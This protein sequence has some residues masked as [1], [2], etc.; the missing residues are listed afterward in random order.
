MKPAARPDD[1][2]TI[3]D[4]FDRGV[5]ISAQQ[6]CLV[7]DTYQAT[8][9]QVRQQSE[10][11]AAQLLARGLAYARIAVLS[12]N[13]PLAVVALL[14]LSRVGGVWITIGVTDPA[15]KIVAMIAR[16]QARL[17]F[18][19]SSCQATI[20]LL[21]KLQPEVQVVCL[22]APLAGVECF[23]D[24]L[25]KPA[26]SLT[27]TPTRPED[28]ADI[29]FTG[30]STGAPKMLQATQRIYETMIATMLL[31][32]QPRQMDRFLVVTPFIHAAGAAALPFLT[33][34]ATVFF[35]SGTHSVDILDAIERHAITHVFLPPTLIYALLNDPTTRKQ[36][37]VS[38]RGI[39]YGA[40]PISEEKL[41]E[42]MELFGPIFH[43]CYGQSEAAMICA[44][45]SPDDHAAALDGSAPQLLRAAGRPTPLMRVEIMNDA[46]ELL[47]A[48]ERGEIVVRGGLVIPGYLDDAAAT[49][50]AQ[51]YGWHHTGDIGVFDDA[52][53]LYVVDRKKDMIISGG[54]NIYPSEIEQVIMEDPAVA[55]C[56]VI[57]VPDEKWGE[58]VTAIVECKAGQQVDSARLIE[59]C[60]QRLGRI[61]APKSVHLWPQLPR[62]PLGKLDKPAIRAQFW[63]G[64]SRNVG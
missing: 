34:G 38:L 21:S 58:A 62:T 42:A 5:R 55:L 28:L 45:L 48:G 40:S 20:Q 59:R 22:D 44:Y 41:R 13:D 24:W 60:R 4:F 19:H 16:T 52:G 47:P 49:A 37:L 9:A 26:G 36:R 32:F 7:S 3:A 2:L 39:I 18:F 54:I 63:A 43:Q 8:F 31:S 61:K 35:S 14:G 12:P 29:C 30:G 23:A 50:A 25:K 27:S 51:A 53:Y 17:V 33:S 57:G 11:V 1:A 10:S 64:R 56:A 6:L 46:G 15:D